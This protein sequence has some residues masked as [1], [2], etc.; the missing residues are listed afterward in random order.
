MPAS[1]KKKG[2]A[3]IGECL[4]E[5][6]GTPFGSLSQTYGGDTLNTALYL[7]RLAGRSID[8]KYVTAVGTDA[9][10]DGMVQRWQAEGIDTTLTLRD[11]ARRPGLYLIQVDARGERTFLYWRGESAARYLLQHSGYHDVAARLAE[12][13]MIYLSG[14][15]LAILPEEDRAMLVGE[16]KRF[17]SHGTAVIFDTNY[18]PALWPSVESARAASSA[19][20]PATRL[21]FVTYDDEQSLWGDRSA[22]DT[23]TRLHAAKAA[24]VVVKL[25]AA[26]CL[27][28]DGA[29][30]TKV[31]ATPVAKVTDTTAAGDAFNAGYL[32]AWLDDR[33]P[34]DCCRAANALAGAVIQHRGA[35][36]PAA[37]TPS[38]AQLLEHRSH[39][40]LVL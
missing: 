37:A 30:V 15:S 13:D 12:A 36:I 34:E 14:I 31:A 4:I 17:A 18:R 9:L 26:G 16:L 11:P 6:N 8:V 32:A 19:L 35:I 25:G 22:E 21:L 10:S 2:I 3:L 28:S 33:G 27:F 5:L 24:F 20:L 7:S 40:G 39:A 23:L 29:T 38:L 1:L